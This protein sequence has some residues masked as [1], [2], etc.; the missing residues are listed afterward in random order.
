MQRMA[1]LD[2]QGLLDFLS[3]GNLP[4]G[5]TVEEGGKKGL[6]V[7]QREVLVA[8]SAF[9]RGVEGSGSSAVVGGDDDPHRGHRDAT[10]EG[11][12]A[13]EAWLNQGIIDKG[14][15]P[16]LGLVGGGDHP[17]FD[18]LEWEVGSS[19][20]NPAHNKPPSIKATRTTEL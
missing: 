5:S 1:Q 2:F 12:A 16:A 13:R 3:C 17:G 19:S 9:A 6:F 18:C 15:A 10:M 7:S 20:R 8:T 14:P 4:F 11:N